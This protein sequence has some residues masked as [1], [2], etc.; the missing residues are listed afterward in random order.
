MPVLLLYRNQSIDLTAS[1]LTGFHM[2]GTLALNVLNTS[3]PNNIPI[4]SC[5]ETLFFDWSGT[6]VTVQKIPQFQLISCCG[7]YSIVSNPT[8]TND[9]LEQLTV[10]L[11]IHSDVHTPFRSSKSRF[12]LSVHNTLNSSPDKHHFFIRAPEERPVFTSTLGKLASYRVQSE[13]FFIKQSTAHLVAH[14]KVCFIG[15]HK[16]NFE[17]NTLAVDWHLGIVAK[18]SS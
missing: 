16:V 7:N 5:S 18:F 1:Q 6:C 11:R 10:T 15:S 8:L 17:I 14:V 3:L 4:H 9:N 12:L 2:R 13:I